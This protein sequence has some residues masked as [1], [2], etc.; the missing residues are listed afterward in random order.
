LAIFPN[1]LHIYLP[2]MICVGVIPTVTSLVVAIYIMKV[3]GEHRRQIKAQGKPKKPPIPNTNWVISILSYIFQNICSVPHVNRPLPH[4]V[5]IRQWPPKWEHFISFSWPPY[6][7][8][9]LCCPTDSLDFR[10]KNHN[11]SA[12]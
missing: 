1:R 7:P 9:S 11:Q 12:E 10:G 2:F 5:P 6:S 3:V 4:S 8:H